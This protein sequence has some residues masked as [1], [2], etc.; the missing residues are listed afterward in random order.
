MRTDAGAYRL[1]VRFKEI[2]SSW[3]SPSHLLAM[4]IRS[5][6]GQEKGRQC[7]YD[8]TRLG[9]CRGLSYLCPTFSLEPGTEQVPSLRSRSCMLF[10]ALMARL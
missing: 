9:T 10:A 8:K 2:E 1:G 4:G 6:D 7:V 3:P 5:P